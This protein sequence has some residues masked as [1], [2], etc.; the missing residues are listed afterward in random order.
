MRIVI[1][2]HNSWSKHVCTVFGRGRR[3]RWCTRKRLHQRQLRGRLST[4]RRLHRDAG[5]AAGNVRRLL[6]N[7]L[8]TALER[9]RHDDAP[10]RTQQGLYLFTS[11]LFTSTVTCIAEEA[12]YCYRRSS[13]VGLCVC[14]SVCLC[15]CWLRTWARQKWLNRSRCCLGTNLG[16]SK[17]MH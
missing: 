5:T 11:F 15:V 7:G 1:A 13:V 4:F 16:G 17:T 3:W 14:L 12:G 6:E 9:H 8:G 2:Y 10:G